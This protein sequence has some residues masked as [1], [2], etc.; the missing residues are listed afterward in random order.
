MNE[1]KKISR[2][3]QDFNPILLFTIIKKNIKWIL[4]ALVAAYLICFMYLRYTQPLYQAKGIIQINNTNVNTNAFVFGNENVFKSNSLDR[5][6]DFLTSKTFL[7]ET[8]NKLNL[9]IDYYVK[10]TVLNSEIFDASPYTIEPKQYTGKFYNIPIYIQYKEGV[11]SKAY[12]E[13]NKQEIELSI[14]QN[15]VIPQKYLLSSKDLELILTQKL[16]TENGIYY[17]YIV[18]TTKLYEK[19]QPFFSAYI[20]N[21]SAQTIEMTFTYP[22][23]KKANIILENILENFS[24]YDKIKQQDEIKNVINYID[25]QLL[26]FEDYVNT[27]E[28]NIFDYKNKNRNN[29]FDSIAS[30]YLINDLGKIIT[31]LSELNKKEHLIQDFAKALLTNKD[32][33]SYQILAQIIGGDFESKFTYSIENLQKLLIEREQAAYDYK[34]NSGK[35]KRIDYEIDM[36]KKILTEIVDLIQKRQVLEKK[37][38]LDEKAKAESQILSQQYDQKSSTELNK[39]NRIFTLNQNFYDK[40]IETKVNYSISA[41]SISS[42]NKILNFTAASTPISPNR[43]M[44]YIVIFGIAIFLTIGAIALQ[45]LYFD[46]IQ[47]I[48]DIQQYT[49][50]SC[51]GQLPYIKRPMTNSILLVDKE[52]KSLLAESLRN[53]R[54]NLQFIDNSDGCKIVTVTSTISGEGKTFAIINL[55]SIFAYSGKKVILIDLDMRKPKIHIAFSDNDKIY[56]NKSGMSQLLVNSL[57]FDDVIQ[58]SRQ[59]NLDFITAGIIPPNPSELILSKRFEEIL[60][61]LKE[62]YDYVFIDAPPIGLVTDGIKCIQLAHFPIYV[63]MSN[64]SRKDFIGNMNAMYEAYHLNKLSFIINAVDMDTKS[65]TYSESYYY[66]KQNYTYGGYTYGGYNYSN[67]YGYTGKYGYNTYDTSTHKDSPKL[68]LKEKIKKM[69]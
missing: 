10:G 62:K 20:L 66:N 67:K 41:A 14:K 9:Q 35:I 53:L 16:P 23:A 50:I 49:K 61:Y 4:L 59:S 60:E 45:Y 31:E 55:A 26:M 13:D 29:I 51:L 52:P 3:N 25:Q 28:E 40:L 5:K 37:K 22:N 54:A 56:H 1:P 17:F 68:S 24:E 7:T 42:D 58:H 43:K 33:S 12:Y 69:I 21:Q 38:L 27:A 15:Q 48:H 44:I 2:I 30:S 34:I 6:L 8:L 19:Y 64:Y 46:K 18:D 47:H 32:I 63:F 57:T 11:I 39:L 65:Y 36:H